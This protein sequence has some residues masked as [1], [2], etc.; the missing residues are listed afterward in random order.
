MSV[1]MDSAGVVALL[2]GFTQLYQL[3]D[4]EH[5]HDHSIDKILLRVG[6]FFA[7]I[8]YIFTGTLGIFPHPHSPRKRIA[9]LH[10]IDSILG[11]VFGTLQ[12]LFI[13][14][15][16]AKTVPPRRG[17]GKQEMPGRQVRFRTLSPSGGCFPHPDELQCVGDV[18]FWAPEAVVYRPRAWLLLQHP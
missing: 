6:V 1:L 11:I 13:E 5:H 9:P 7:Y 14:L 18:H 2:V 10:I 3:P 15:L 16:I 4:K 17:G 12:I 8:Y